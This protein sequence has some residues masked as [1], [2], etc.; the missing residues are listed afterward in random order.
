[1]TVENCRGCERPAEQNPCE[2]CGIATHCTRCDEWLDGPFCRACGSEALPPL[3]A[4]ESSDSQAA[5]TASSL[6][7]VAAPFAEFVRSTNAAEASWVDP[8]PLEAPT[9]DLGGSFH[10]AF[11]AL[12]NNLVPIALLQLITFGV[13]ATATVAAL[14]IIGVGVDSDVA[15]MHVVALGV[16]TAMLIPVFAW[17]RLC[18]VQAWSMAVRGVPVQLGDALFPRR[19]LPFL[20]TTLLVAPAVW[21]TGLL[22]FAFA[23]KA[24]LIAVADGLGP[25]AAI[26]RML[27]ETCSTSKRF[28]HTLLIGLACAI[29]VAFTLAAVSFVS[30]FVEFGLMQSMFS[31]AV[32]GSNSLRSTDRGVTKLVSYGFIFLSAVTVLSATKQIVGL[33]AAAHLRRLTGRPVGARVDEPSQ[34]TEVPR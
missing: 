30:S 9:D 4:P 26:G 13:S 10:W 21:F 14:L 18:S 20:G 29:T 2:H 12:R 27:S 5:A 6:S 3:A 24:Q 28:F 22:G 25:S 33:W 16:A 34:L 11:S 8:L 7:P 31:E 1:M 23:A 17:S 32:E 15:L 19:Y